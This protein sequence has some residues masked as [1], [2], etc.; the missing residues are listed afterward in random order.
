[1]RK[2]TLFEIKMS[3]LETSM[4]DKN[5]EKNG[6]NFFIPHHVFFYSTFQVSKAKL[7]KQPLAQCPRD[8]FII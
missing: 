5:R 8:I 4:L 1:M 2:K 3:H 7:E 6:N